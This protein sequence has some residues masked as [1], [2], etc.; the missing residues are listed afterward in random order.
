M[1]HSYDFSKLFRHIKDNQIF[2][3]TYFKLKFDLLDDNFLIDKN[4]FSKYYGN[5]NNGHYHVIFFKAGL[6]AIIKKWL[7][8]GCMET[9]E[10][11]YDIIKSEYKKELS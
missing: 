1:K 10:E 4:E 6:N 2:Y 3:K 11:L 5:D 7:D 8:D 9:P